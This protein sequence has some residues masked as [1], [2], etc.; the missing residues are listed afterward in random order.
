MFQDVLTPALYRL[1]VMKDEELFTPD[2]AS[3]PCC[4]I[5]LL[6]LAR[7][8]DTWGWDRQP[9]TGTQPGLCKD[10]VQTRVNMNSAMKLMVF[11][12][13]FLTACS[14]SLSPWEQCLL[15]LGQERLC[16][17]EQVAYFI[18]RTPRSR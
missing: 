7:P 1:P 11:K 3:F 13:V 17:P 5:S 10:L 18:L 14:L 6:L 8:P 12:D 2:P 16:F 15:V 9:E 4:L